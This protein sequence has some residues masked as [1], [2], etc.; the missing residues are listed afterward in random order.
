[1]KCLSI[2]QPWAGLI[3]AGV[4]KIE[5]RSWHTPHRGKILIHAGRRIN[6]I[7]PTSLDVNIS[8]CESLVAARGVVIG[9]ANLVDC[10]PAKPDDYHDALCEIKEGMFAW[11]L[12]SAH[13]IPPF[14]L[15]GK[16]GLFEVN[17][18]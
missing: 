4:K 17:I 8:V 6:R 9:E 7:H 2:Q 15:K 1:M 14:E 16:L 3:V 18:K 12:D 11:V 10:R 5:C 13:S